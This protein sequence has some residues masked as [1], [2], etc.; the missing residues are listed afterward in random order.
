MQKWHHP[1][2]IASEGRAALILFA[3]IGSVVAVAFYDSRARKVQAL[4]RQPA[5]YGLTL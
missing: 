5:A 3:M 2:L 4:Q 1:L